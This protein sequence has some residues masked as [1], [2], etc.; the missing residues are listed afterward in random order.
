M[1]SADA[2]PARKIVANFFISMDGVVEAPHE[3]HFPYFNEEMGQAVESG[4]EGNDAMLMGANLYR[5]WSEYWP[6]SEDEFA[7]FINATP[8]YVISNSLDKL[9]WQ[10]SHLIK[11]DEAVERIRELKAQPGKNI[12][13]SGCATTVRWLLREGLLDELHLLVHPIAVGKG[14]HLFDDTTPTQKLEL[15]SSKAFTTGV[16][17]NIYRP[18]A[19]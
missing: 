17:Y 2:A 6:T 16:L 4:V 5:E 1:T 12:G 15:V 11:G 18:V 19:D 8:K 3:W 10:N 9:D 13:M 14:Q 7:G